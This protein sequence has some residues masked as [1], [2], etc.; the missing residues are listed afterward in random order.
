LHI[1]AY[2]SLINNRKK[3]NKQHIKIPKRNLQKLRRK[4]KRKI[5]YFIKESK[6][7]TLTLH[8]HGILTKKNSENFKEQV[9]QN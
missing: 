1:E 4:I 6:M 7:E 8:Q 9:T 5:S 2:H 3:E